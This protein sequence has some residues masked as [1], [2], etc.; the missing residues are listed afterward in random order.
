MCV[1]VCVLTVFIYLLFFF[2]CVGVLPF[3]GEIKMYIYIIAR[4]HS[5]HAERNI[6]LENPSVRPYL[7]V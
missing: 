4:Q 6:V 3:D 2:E 5:M 7:S 1:C